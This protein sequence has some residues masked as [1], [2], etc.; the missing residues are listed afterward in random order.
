MNVVDSSDT[1]TLGVSLSDLTFAEDGNPDFLKQVFHWTFSNKCLMRM[2]DGKL[3]N[4]TK[5]ELISKIIMDVQLNQQPSYT[6]PGISLLS[7]C[8]AEVR[9]VLEPLYTFLLQLP[10]AEEKELYDLSLLR[11]P[12]QQQ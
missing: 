8:V 4:W 2:K 3:I 5:R 9:K 12:R 1:R 11:E 10:C 6:F 7:F